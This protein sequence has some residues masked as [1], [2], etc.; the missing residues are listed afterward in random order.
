MKFFFL[1]KNDVV[2]WNKVFALQFLWKTPILILSFVVDFVKFYYVSC[3]WMSISVL[4]LSLKNKQLKLQFEGLHLIWELDWTW[5]VVVEKFLRVAYGFILTNFVSSIV[6]VCLWRHSS[7]N[8]CEDGMFHKE[9]SN[10][11]E[12]QSK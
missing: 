5:S 9:G 7:Q 2:E 12:A 6:L 11:D 4:T 3:Y 10:W 1:F 8:E